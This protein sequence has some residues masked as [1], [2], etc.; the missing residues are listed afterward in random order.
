MKKP[1]IEVEVVPNTRKLFKIAYI[2]LVFVFITELISYFISYKA[3]EAKIPSLNISKI[4]ANKTKF[5]FN[6]LLGHFITIVFS[7]VLEELA[8]R[9]SMNG[10]LKNNNLK[11]Y[12]FIAFLYGLFI[13]SLPLTKFYS[14]TLVTNRIFKNFNY[15]KTLDL[16]NYIYIIESLIPVLIFIVV[17]CIIKILRINMSAILSIINNFIN[18]Y[19]YVFYTLSTIVWIQLHFMSIPFKGDSW[20]DI[21][22]V[23]NLILISYVFT[24]YSKLISIKAGILIHM[25]HNTFIT[26]GGLLFTFD[27]FKYIY[28]IFLTIV[29]L[30]L[31]YVLKRELKKFNAGTIIEF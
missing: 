13:A 24:L 18:K 25:I 3:F 9:Y 31:I 17:F 8:F 27:S 16:S 19:C 12:S 2:F 29:I 23:I 1:N 21:W 4:L 7:P 14:Y 6:T 26:I 10:K 28:S 22:F 30:G 15:L 20:S 5:N 11:I